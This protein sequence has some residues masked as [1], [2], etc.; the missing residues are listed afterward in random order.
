[1]W[2]RELSE[3]IRHSLWF[4]PAISVV[5]AAAAAIGLVALSSAL[6]QD[7]DLP[8]TFSAGPEGARAMLGAIAGSVITVAGTVFS[9]T[10]VALQLTSTQFSPRVLRNFLRDRA[11]QAV[12]GVFIG[13]FTYCLLVLR[14]I[15]SADE[16]GSPAFVPGLA[17]TGGLLLAFVSLGMLIYFI[18]HTS[19]R[20]QVTTI[21]ASVAEDALGSV[22]HV[23]GWN[24]PD[25]RRPWRPATA[26]VRAAPAP[27]SGA[28]PAGDQ[29]DGARTLAID[30]SGYLQL[31]DLDGLVRHA[32]EAGGRYLLLVAPGAWVLAHAPIA[33]FAP[34]SGSAPAEAVGHARLEEALVL[35]AERSLRQDPA[36]GIQ[37]LADIGMKALS[38]SV[39]D[40]TT[41]INAIDRLGQ[42]LV[43][44][45]REPD[46]PRAFADTDGVVRL[47]VPFPGFDELT[48]L[49]FGQLRFYGAAT[50]AVAVH[51]ARTLTLLT[52]TLPAERHPVLRRQAELLADA[53][54]TIPLEGDR[55]EARA[56]VGPLR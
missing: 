2:V 33:T 15:R 37:Q 5:V 39:N 40:P 44:A 10:I 18:H 49:A 21:L 50:P 36:F 51:L 43:A 45:G 30:R 56:A 9:I 52:A 16:S 19:V 4:I 3:R 34:D 23:A 28:I 35:A 54:D 17:V 22:H 1:M 25:E 12:L 38:P 6:G 41:A 20:I 42:V 32:R 26:P 29:P 7:A 14:T 31:V 24:R 55:R 53:I 8:L 27:P 48:A 47:E 46:A 11:N 13:T